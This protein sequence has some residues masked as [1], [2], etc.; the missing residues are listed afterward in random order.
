MWHSGLVRICQ[1][2][3]D[4]QKAEI[5][6]DNSFVELPKYALAYAAHKMYLTVVWPPPADQGTCENVF[7]FNI[8]CWRFGASHSLL[9]WPSEGQTKQTLINYC[10]PQDWLC[11]SWNTTD[12]LATH[13]KRWRHLF[14]NLKLHIWS[15]FGMTRVDTKCEQWLGSVRK[16]LGVYGVSVTFM[17]TGYMYH[18]YDLRTGDWMTVWCQP[19]TSPVNTK[20]TYVCVCV[21]VCVCMCV[22]VCAC[23]DTSERSDHR[24]WW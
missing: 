10:Q 3:T 24:G 12:E 5:C 11:V 4:W 1:P 2:A 22:C 23:Q 21:C 20:H 13:I 15:C 16:C 8:F 6:F 17:S 19:A 7:Q 9:N 14:A 18:K